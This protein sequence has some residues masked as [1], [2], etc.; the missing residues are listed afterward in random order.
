LLAFINNLIEIKVDKWKLMN[1]TKRPFPLGADSI[2][3]WMIIFTSITYVGIFSSWGIVCI[4]KQSFSL[5]STKSLWIFL[6]LSF[7]S[8]LLKFVLSYLIPD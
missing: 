8:L 7:G 1:F 2:G 4:T 3:V 6:I 5:D